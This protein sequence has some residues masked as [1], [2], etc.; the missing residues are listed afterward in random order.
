[1]ASIPHQDLFCKP[2]LKMVPPHMLR[3]IHSAYRTVTRTD[4]SFKVIKAYTDAVNNAVEYV[5]ALEFKR[6][7]ATAVSLLQEAV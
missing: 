5:S 7:T 4:A 1:M 2:H 3:D 6:I